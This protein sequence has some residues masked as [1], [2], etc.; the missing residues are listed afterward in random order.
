[1]TDGLSSVEPNRTDRRYG[2]LVINSAYGPVMPRRA[3]H[4]ANSPSGTARAPNEASHSR[5]AFSSMASNTGVRS[6]ADALMTCSTSEVAV[7]CS[8]ASFSSLI[9]SETV[10]RLRSVAAGAT[11]RLVVPRPFTC[12]AF[13]ASALLA[14]PCVERRAISAS[15]FRT[16]YYR[17]EPSYWKGRIGRPARFWGVHW[18]STRASLK[19]VHLVIAD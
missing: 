4:R 3:T 5:I 13:A 9:K 1:M 19:S 16:A 10:R 6:P 18:V 14:L 8:R 7:C 15:E 17:A 12:L 11:R 2:L